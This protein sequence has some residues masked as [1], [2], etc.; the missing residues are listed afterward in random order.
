MLVIDDSTMTYDRSRVVEL[1]AWKTLLIY[2]I[3]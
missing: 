3:Y 1:L 2:T